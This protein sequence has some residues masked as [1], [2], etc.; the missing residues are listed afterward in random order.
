[1]LWP[2]L[3]R[4]AQHWRRCAAPKRRAA[5]KFRVRAFGLGNTVR[6]NERATPDAVRQFLTRARSLCR[7][8]G[9]RRDETRWLQLIPPRNTQ[10]FRAWI[11]E[12]LARRLRYLGQ[13]QAEKSS[14]FLVCSW[15]IACV[16]TFCLYRDC[17][18]TIP[19]F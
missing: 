8:A 17:N 1:M 7:H 14:W 4:A 12:N 15:C 13:F 6:K 2:P 11:K 5:V 19:L 10:P 16:L 3:Y 18:L 9:C